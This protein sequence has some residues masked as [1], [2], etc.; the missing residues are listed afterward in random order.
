MLKF[1]KKYIRNFFCI[2]LVCFVGFLSSCRTVSTVALVGGFLCEVAGIEGSED[3][4][5]S[6]ID[7]AESIE[8]AMEDF[9]PEQEYYIGRAVAASI[10]ANLI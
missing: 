7:S 4:A 2:A 3:I 9:T 8:K 10:L 5:L 1:C 6:I